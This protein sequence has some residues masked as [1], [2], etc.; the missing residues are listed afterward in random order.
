MG[1]IADKLTHLAQT[2]E[3][4]R[5]AIESKGVAAPENTPFREY[6][7]LIG[8]IETGEKMPDKI[9]YY[10]NMNGHEYIAA[11]YTVKTV[12]ITNAQAEDYTY[13]WEPLNTS[14]KWCGASTAVGRTNTN[15]SGTTRT[16]N[17]EI[18]LQLPAV[19]F[20]DVNVDNGFDNGCPGFTFGGWFNRDS[21]WTSTYYRA[22]Y[23]K[24]AGVFGCYTN[25][26]NP[27]YLAIDV[28]GAAKT[29]LYQL[30]YNT[31]YHLALTIEQT[32]SGVLTERFYV[33]S[34]LVATYS[35][36]YTI[37]FTKVSIGSASIY[38]WGGYMKN[39]FASWGAL[40]QEE[41]RQMMLRD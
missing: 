12:K 26:D 29:K 24:G 31:W 15:I 28:A 20:P 18:A 30:S 14:G 25:P 36:S 39:V 10:N 37:D 32:S 17:Y 34:V 13:T 5:T 19:K 2:K 23:A 40:T 3:Q 35:T 41:I 11:G 1:T 8:R 21:A 7:Q 9:I 33:N 16:E 38:G 22:L 27:N 6:P 4:I